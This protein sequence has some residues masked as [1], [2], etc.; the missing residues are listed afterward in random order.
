M[1]KYEKESEFQILFKKQDQFLNSKSRTYSG[2]I[3]KSD[4][5]NDNLL[6]FTRKYVGTNE[7]LMKCMQ[8]FITEFHQRKPVATTIQPTQPRSGMSNVRGICM[9]R[10]VYS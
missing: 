8:D 10:S 4:Q 1:N 3:D 5:D 9:C 2:L 6:V 7:Q